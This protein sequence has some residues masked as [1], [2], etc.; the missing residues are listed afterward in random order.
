MPEKSEPAKLSDLVRY[1]APYRF[2]REV[3][4][5]KTGAD[6]AF[7][8]VCKDDTGQAPLA[9]TDETDAN[10]IHIGDPITT[11]GAGATSLFLVRHC[12]VSKNELTYSGGVT[13][14]TVD[15]TLKGLGIIPRSEP[16][17][18]ETQTT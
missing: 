10:A 6:L 1:E 18:T 12:I 9:G 11:A 15:S 14:A 7:G 5:V 2:S 4:T 13:E 8:E 3:M 16:T 17:K